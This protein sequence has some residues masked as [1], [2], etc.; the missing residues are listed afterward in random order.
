MTGGKAITGGKA[1][2]IDATFVNLIHR[3]NVGDSLTRS[4]WRRPDALAVVD[5][6]RS[7]SY[8]EFNNWVNRIAHGLL[9]RGYA[10]GDVIALVSGNRAEF[11][12]TY[13][14]CAKIGVVTVPINLGW[15]TDEVAYALGHSSARG[16][17]IEP[18][19]LDR[20]RDAAEGASTLSEIYVLSD[21]STAPSG[22]HGGRTLLTFD[23]LEHSDESEPEVFVDD[24]DPITYLY[25]SG[26]TSAPKGA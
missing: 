12:V 21:S 4:A 15:R 26:T 1:M 17:V 6:G 19:L 23:E 10:R 16:V 7:Y 3:V 24:R 18:S 20:Y 8:R 2:T 14:A 11:L 22:D 13:Y 5:M 9:R 25:T